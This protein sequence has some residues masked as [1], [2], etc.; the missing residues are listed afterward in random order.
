MPTHPDAVRLQALHDD[1]SA[2]V[3]EKYIKKRQRKIMWAHL[4]SVLFECERLLKGLSS[5]N[6]F[7][8]V[9]TDPEALAFIE[10]H[11][12]SHLIPVPTPRTWVHPLDRTED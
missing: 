6:T 7:D 1:I 8:I 9:P 3:K 11:G 4:D 10:K 2:H 5:I 12:L